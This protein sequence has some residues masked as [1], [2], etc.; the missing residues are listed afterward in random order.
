MLGFTVG[1]R[2][3][4]AQE[5]HKSWRHVGL[6]ELLSRRCVLVPRGAQWGCSSA[7]PA[8]KAMPYLR[9]GRKVLTAHLSIAQAG[10]LSHKALSGQGPCAWE[11][12][13]RPPSVQHHSPL[14]KALG[15][16]LQWD[17]WNSSGQGLGGFGTAPKG[18][19]K[20]CSTTPLGLVPDY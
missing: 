1:R 16:V 3:R 20:M 9:I 12:L 5:H 17:G 13:S 2:S 11:Q 14:C 6:A 19:E 18:R 15:S 8:G 7:A 4:D 10:E